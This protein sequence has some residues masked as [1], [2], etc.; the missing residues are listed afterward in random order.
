MPFP[1]ACPIRNLFPPLG[2]S[3]NP[4]GMQQPAKGTADS[5]LGAGHRPIIGDVFETE[6][7]EPQRGD[8]SQGRLEQ[9]SRTLSESTAEKYRISVEMVRRRQEILPFVKFILPRAHR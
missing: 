2:F 5:W 4:T 1:D 6:R 8:L 9:T 3:R 7:D